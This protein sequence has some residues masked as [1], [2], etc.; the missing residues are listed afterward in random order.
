MSA[1][2]KDDKAIPIPIPRDDATEKKD[3]TTPSS[4]T[5]PKRPGDDLASASTRP[6]DEDDIAVLKTYAAGPYTNSIKKLEDEV[7]SL[8]GKVNTLKGVKESDTGLSP[9]SQWDLVADK[10]MMMMEQT[11]Q[12][13]RCT[14]II[15]PNTPQVRLRPRQHNR[16]SF[17]IPYI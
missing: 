4:V 8:V 15:A 9:P 14:K 11:L 10:Q 5:D 17:T 3:D 2:N 12:V 13:A 1:P 16:A 7:K 6:L